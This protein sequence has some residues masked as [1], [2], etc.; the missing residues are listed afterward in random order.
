MGREGELQEGNMP[1]RAEKSL[2]A[3]R[4]GAITWTATKGPTKASSTN[5]RTIKA[6]C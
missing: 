6:T 5:Q 2:R 4:R 1:A 3:V